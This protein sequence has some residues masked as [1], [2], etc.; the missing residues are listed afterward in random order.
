MASCMDLIV[1]SQL[2]MM[3]PV[4]TNDDEGGST[5]PDG[6]TATAPVPVAVSVVAVAVVD[7]VSTLGMAFGELANR[8]SPS[9]RS[10]SMATAARRPRV[11]FPVN[12]FCTHTTPFR[13]LRL[14]LSIALE[15]ALVVRPLSDFALDV[16][17][18]AWHFLA[19][20]AAAAVALRPV[21][22]GR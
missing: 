16:F 19:R 7:V 5:V 12:A 10:S 6:A 20:F 15:L 18:V 1:L 22:V 21:L 14:E 17:F 11:H 9:S 2:E 3:L 4:L 13:V 8:F